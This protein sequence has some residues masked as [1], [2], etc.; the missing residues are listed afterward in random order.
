[1][2][3]QLSYVPSMGAHSTQ[4]FLAVNRFFR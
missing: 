2:L 3:Y 1:V 4:I